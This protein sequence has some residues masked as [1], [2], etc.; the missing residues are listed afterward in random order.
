MKIQRS[1][2]NK[3][4][5][6]AI[7]NGEFEDDDAQ[8]V[9]GI[10]SMDNG[11]M[12]RR[13]RQHAAQTA[14]Q[15][16]ERNYSAGKLPRD[17]NGQVP[18]RSRFVGTRR[19]LNRMAEQR[20]HE[21]DEPV[22]LV[23]AFT[24][25]ICRQ[26]FQCKPDG[27]PARRPVSGNGASGNIVA[28]KAVS[29]AVSTTQSHPKLLQLL[30][31]DGESIVVQ[32]S[33]SMQS[34]ALPE[35]GQRYQAKVL[36]ITGREYT[37]DRVVFVLDKEEID[38]IKYPIS[39]YCSLI[40]VD[41]KA[42]M[43]QFTDK[44]K[45][46][47]YALDFS[48]PSGKQ[49]FDDS[50]RKLVDRSKHKE[51]ATDI[52]TLKT[53][54]TPTRAAVPSPPANPPA[55]P[56]IP[57]SRVSPQLTESQLDEIVACVA[58][59][60]IYMRDCTPDDYSIDVMKSVIRG[61]T[62]AFMMRQN[63]DFAKLTSRNRAELVEGHWIPAVTERFF[64]WLRSSQRGK[65]KELQTE[66]LDNQDLLNNKVRRVYSRVELMALKSAAVDMSHMLPDK[67][68]FEASNTSARRS[69]QPRDVQRATTS[70]PSIGSQIQRTASAV[71]WVHHRDKDRATLPKLK[72]STRFSPKSNPS[73]SVTVQSGPTTE[74][75]TVDHDASQ[76]VADWVFGPKK[77][78]PAKKHTGL[79]NSM[80]NLTNA[81]VLCGNSGQ[82]TGVFTQSADFQDLVEIFDKADKSRGDMSP[83]T[84]EF[85]QLSL[86]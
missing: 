50:L 34:A 13:R 5:T 33:V 1:T 47:F 15:Y 25:A 78:G 77:T 58:D 53:D 23:A 52:S 6:A 37:D 38:D 24:T 30:L 68:M 64:G 80:H 26:T 8:Q 16:V 14:F 44:G 55:S 67:T 69:E 29:P 70:V 56:R 39:Q 46:V 10:D 40:D 72:D 66:C 48:V 21:S 17:Q 63:P 61:A 35:R 82:F 19:N 76:E 32:L 31:P 85:R 60:A 27:G 59:T 7:T 41:S 71:D 45:P 57:G 3:K 9:K 62:A 11:N 36:L 22:N 51:V 73:D 84:R 75:V 49:A 79:N 18:P 2:I 74:V 86:E 43:L 42:L 83:L 4:W 81:D 12:A 20:R 65:E 28:P 54:G